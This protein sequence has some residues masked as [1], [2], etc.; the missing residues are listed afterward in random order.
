MKYRLCAAVVLHLFTEFTHDVFL[1]PIKAS[2]L[3][4]CGFT[5]YLEDGHQSPVSYIFC[6]I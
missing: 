2:G 4:M 3:Q 6:Q 1:C 5:F